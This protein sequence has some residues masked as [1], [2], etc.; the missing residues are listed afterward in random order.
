MDPDVQR[1]V[2]GLM[3]R[4]AVRGLYGLMLV[5]ATLIGSMYAVGFNAANLGEAVGIFGPTHLPAWH[6]PVWLIANAVGLLVSSLVATHRLAGR[7]PGSFGIRW[8]RVVRSLHLWFE[9]G[10]DISLLDLVTREPF[11]WRRA[12]LWVVYMGGLVALWLLMATYLVYQAFTL[13]A[14]RHHAPWPARGPSWWQRWQQR[15][16]SEHP[17]VRIEAEQAALR[18]AIAKD[19]TGPELP[20]TSAAGETAPHGRR[21]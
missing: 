14:A 15:V 10:L 21:L 19:S 12:V 9:N 6:R 20:G 4:E 8:W 3:L 18:R 2:R 16:L 13:R 17:E 5:V 1:K 7:L 11:T